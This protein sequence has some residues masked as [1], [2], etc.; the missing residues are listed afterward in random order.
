MDLI[1][2]FIHIP[3]NEA[4]NN[5]KFIKQMNLHV[6]GTGEI[7]GQIR[8]GKIGGHKSEMTPEMIAKF[9]QWMQEG[10]KLNQGFLYA[11]K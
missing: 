11:T 9:D 4:V 2:K 5:D 7:H 10:L 8:S 3:E 6:G 1:K